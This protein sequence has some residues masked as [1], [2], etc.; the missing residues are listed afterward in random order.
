MVNVALESLFGR[1]V[2][3]IAAKAAI[4]F[5]SP[6]PFAKGLYIDQEKLAFQMSKRFHQMFRPVEKADQTC[7]DLLSHG[8]VEGD[9]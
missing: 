3:N 9:R 4:L 7:T 8:V 5:S 1:F 2:G 6:E